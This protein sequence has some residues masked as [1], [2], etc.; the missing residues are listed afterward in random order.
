[1]HLPKETIAW[2]N[3]PNEGGPLFGMMKL[4]TDISQVSADIGNTDV[5]D[6]EAYE[7]LFNECLT[8]ER[9]HMEL[10]SEIGQNIDGEPRTYAHGELKTGVPPTDHLFGPAYRFSSLED[11]MLH[12][13]FWLSLSALYP[14]IRQC[15]IHS[16]S[17]INKRSQKDDADDAAKTHRLM[18][19]YANKAARCLPYCGQEGMN[20]FGLYYGLVCTGHLSR[21]YAHANVKDW[22]RFLWAQDVFSFM[23]ISG[24]EY[25]ARFRE[26]W[27][28]YWFTSYG[29]DSCE[30]LNFR[31]LAPKSKQT[32]YEVEKRLAWNWED[33]HKTITLKP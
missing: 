18:I 28:N 3:E 15:R 30:V 14:L 8:I 33:I 23:E 6:H 29:Q 13:F 12:L 27:W 31:R 10:Y 11:A 4:L 2:L 17:G 25:A 32:P 1:M 16:T 9:D 20:T 5:S 22:P 19:G 7:S 26:I 24:L 21:I